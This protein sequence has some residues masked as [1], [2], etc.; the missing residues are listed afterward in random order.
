[1][2]TVPGE[3]VVRGRQTESYHVAVVLVGS[4]GASSAG[5]VSGP[6]RRCVAC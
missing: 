5:E 6:L 3:V 2:P 4:L 1:M